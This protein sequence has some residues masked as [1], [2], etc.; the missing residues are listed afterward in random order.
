MVVQGMVCYQTLLLQEPQQT[1]ELRQ[2]H[3]SPFSHW[4]DP[5]SRCC[6][7]CPYPQSLQPPCLAVFPKKRRARLLL[8]REARKRCKPQSELLL[9][10]DQQQHRGLWPGNRHPRSRGYKFARQQLHLV[11]RNN[12]GLVG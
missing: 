9:H 11:V 12:Q 7:Y 2:Q 1:A 5:T 4:H 3:I 6:R 10:Q 8:W